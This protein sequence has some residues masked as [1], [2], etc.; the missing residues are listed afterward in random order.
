MATAARTLE[1]LETEIAILE[2]LVAKAETVRVARVDAKWEALAELLTSDQMYDESGGRRKIIIFTEHRD[3]LEYLEQRLSEL[4][5]PST[6]VEVI[7]GAISRPDRRLAQIR[8]T[9]EPNSSILLATD[10]AGEGVNLQVAHLMVN[11][12]IP[13]NPNRLEQRF[14]RIHRI[15]QRHVCHLW[16]L[17]AVDTR[18][19]DVF[20]TL[21]R[22]ARG[23]ARGLGRPGLRRPGPGPDRRQ[24]RPTALPSLGGRRRSRGRVRARA[25]SPPTWSPRFVERAASVSTLTPDELA[26]LRRQ[27]ELARASSFQPD[28]VRDFTLT[29]LSRFRGDIAAPRR[30]V[31][32]PSRARTRARVTGA[33]R[34]SPLRPD[35]LRAP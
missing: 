19:G 10:A 9:Q 33:G 6:G 34:S 11:Y 23:A 4:L 15:G 35:H 1:E 3:T 8:F 21:A 26:V 7:H 17:V 22:Q 5:P 16:N 30:H 32:G 29:A 13:W 2:R 12:D 28:V 27:M 31:A 14:G 24:P 20:R 25:G 18:E